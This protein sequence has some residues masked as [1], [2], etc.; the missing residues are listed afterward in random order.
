MASFWDE[1]F[2][3]IEPASSEFDVESPVPSTLY[4]NAEQLIVKKTDPFGHLSR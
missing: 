3:G 1:L 4:L 2:W